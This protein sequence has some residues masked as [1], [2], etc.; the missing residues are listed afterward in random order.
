MLIGIDVGNVGMFVN[1][2]HLSDVDP[3]VGD[4]HIIHVDAAGVV[5]GHKN[6]TRAESEPAHRT[7]ANADTDAKTAAAH[8]SYAGWSIDGTHNDGTG[9]PAPSTA[10]EGPA[11]VVERCE[12]PRLIFH[13]GP[14]PGSDPDPV[15]EAIGGPSHKNADGSPDRAVVSDVVPVSI[16]VEVVSPGHFRRNVIR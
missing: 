11:P 2:V 7:D 6:L 10:D 13:P 4:V 1:V 3:R 15:A 14:T 12:A 5:P 8:E 9:D 16:F